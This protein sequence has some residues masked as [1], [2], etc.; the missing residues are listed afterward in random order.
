MTIVLH[1]CPNGE[2][3]H[4]VDTSHKRKSPHRPDTTAPH[5]MI[6]VGEGISVS[7]SLRLCG[8]RY[9]PNAEIV[10]PGQRFMSAK[11]AD[12]YTY[13]CNDG[14]KHIY[15]IEYAHGQVCVSD[16]WDSVF[17]LVQ[18]GTLVPIGSSAPPNFKKNARKPK[19]QGGMTKYLARR[20]RNAGYILQRDAGKDNLSF[21]TLTLPDLSDEDL[22]KCTRHWSKMVNKFLVWLRYRC[23]RLSIPFEYVYCT[24]IQSKRLQLRGEYALHLHLLFRGRETRKAP[25]AITPR[26][27]RKEWVRC[28]KSVLGHSNFKSTA[29][30]NLQRVRS[31]AAGYL[32]KYM[33]KGSNALLKANEKSVLC[34]TSIEW[35]GMARVLSQTITRES[36]TVR[37]D[38]KASDFAWGFTRGLPL[39]VEEGYIAFYKAGY[40][41]I[42]A[43]DGSNNPNCL[44]VGV[45]RLAQNLSESLIYEI[46]EFLL[47]YQDTDLTSGEITS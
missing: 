18:D 15:A 34:S 43:S 36:L 28:I 14:G 16:L 3:T 1:F 12:M 35:G 20:I 24:E 25:W 22:G 26:Q 37:G 38:G 9:Y 42:R 39:L 23:E 31:N 19:G 44:K 13:L 6:P 2:F 32:S 40:I 29:L 7:D 10:E 21:L 46:H 27:A 41:R 17:N 8:K 45:G 4:G 33:S 11:N 47:S 5:E 30:E